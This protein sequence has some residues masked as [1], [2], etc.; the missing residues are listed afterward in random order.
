MSRRTLD[1]N[2]MGD[3]VGVFTF[4]LETQHRE[5]CLEWSRFTVSYTCDCRMTE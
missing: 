1:L 4:L 2:S 3:R 5:P